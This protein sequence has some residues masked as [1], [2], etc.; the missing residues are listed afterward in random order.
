MKFGLIFILGS[1]ITG[2][3]YRYNSVFLWLVGVAIG[4]YLGYKLSEYVISKLHIRHYFNTMRIVLMAIGLVLV[5]IGIKES[6][7]LE[8]I[9]TLLFMISILSTYKSDINK[10]YRKGDN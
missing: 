1:I 4:W 6:I 7:L 10:N 3:G 9:G 2:L 8:I 5:V